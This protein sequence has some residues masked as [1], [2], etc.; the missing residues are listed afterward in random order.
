MGAIVHLY[1]TLFWYDWETGPKVMFSF[2]HAFICVWR[3]ILITAAW[4]WARWGMGRCTGIRRRMWRI[5][6]WRL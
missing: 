5:V 1:L 2:L 4:C 6:G 3:R